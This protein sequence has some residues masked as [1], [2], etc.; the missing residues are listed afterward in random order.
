MIEQALLIGLCAWRLTALVSYERGPFDIFLRARAA[1]GFEHGDD[2]EPT[3]WPENAL[4]RMIS[5][6]WCLGLWMLAPVYGL[7]CLEPVL[8]MLGAAGA[9]LVAVERWNHGTR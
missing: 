4:T 2:G 3:G 7:W 8:V 6:P 9:V 5:C 1:L